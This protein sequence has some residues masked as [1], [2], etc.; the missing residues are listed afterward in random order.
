MWPWSYNKCKRGYRYSQEISACSKVTHFDM[1]PREG[2][3]APEIDILE[4]MG[5]E[6][7]PLPNTHIE[8]PYFSASYQ[9]SPGIEG[10]RPI[11]GFQPEKVRSIKKFIN[12]LILAHFIY[13]RTS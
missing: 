13:S 10:S 4:A 5:G 12:N 3:G 6:V 1:T 11:T 2:R 7:G 8:R 9:V